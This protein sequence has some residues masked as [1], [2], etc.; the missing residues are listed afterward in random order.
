MPDRSRSGRGDRGA[1]PP[2]AP[3]GPPAAPPGPR[4]GPRRVEPQTTQ[5]PSCGPAWAPHR[6]QMRPDQETGGG[7][8][9][10]RSLGSTAPG[11][12]AHEQ[13]HEAGG[14]CPG[15]AYGR[16]WRAWGTPSSWRT[17]SARS[18]PTT[19]TATRRP[20]TTAPAASAR[21]E[22]PSFIG[23]RPAPGHRPGVGRPAQPASP[24]WG[25]RREAAPH[26]STRVALARP[27][28]VRPPASAWATF[29]AAAPTLS[30]AASLADAIS[31]A[32]ACT[33][34]PDSPQGRAGGRDA[35]GHPNDRTS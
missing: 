35:R 7:G 30:A 34:P 17:M 6:R 14:R 24:S 2:P 18:P 23:R 33:R 29:R 27:G 10:A 8:A 4:A 15:C 11:A 3:G 21:S 19:K 12:R 13:E 5:T 22:T 25:Q 32:R 9:D 28:D 26:G 31:R 16:A 1:P 20:T